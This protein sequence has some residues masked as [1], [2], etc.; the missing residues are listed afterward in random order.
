MVRR[1]DEAA[2]GTTMGKQP[3][4]G[5]GKRPG[6]GGGKGPPGGRLRGEGRDLDAL[7]QHR[8]SLF[9]ACQELVA[10]ADAGT[11]H[12]SEYEQRIVT[13]MKAMAAAGFKPKGGASHGGD[14][15][16]APPISAVPTPADELLQKPPSL[17]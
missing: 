13:Q 12:L 17:D 7:K 15:A 5:G 4:K 10:A 11:V 8:A 6:R 16:A 9:A 1:D 2:K 14:L 3:G